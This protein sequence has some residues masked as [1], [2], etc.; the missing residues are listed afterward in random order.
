M[1]TMTPAPIAMTH[2]VTWQD[3]T[4]L[5]NPSFTWAQIAPYVNW[6]V[7]SP[8]DNAN[9][10]AVGIKTVL[11]TDPNRVDAN[12]PEYSND[13]T[14]FA[15]DCSNNRITI[16]G[17]QSLT[18]L[19]DPTS[20]VLEGLWQQHLA[21]YNQGGHAQ[22]NMVFD[23]TPIVASVSALPCGYSQSAW[24]AAENL[25]NIG[26]NYPI[27]FNGLANLANGMGQ[28]SPAMAL[29][30]T[31]SGGEMEGCYSNYSGSP[32]P[33]LTVWHTFEDTEIQVLADGKLF[34]CRGF[35]NTPDTQAQVQ[36]LY[37]YGSFL[38]TYDPALA[39]FS[40]KFK[41]VSNGMWIQPEN[42]LV[43]LDPIMMQPSSIDQLSLGANVYGRQYRNCYYA[44]QWVGACAS[45]VNS[46]SAGASHP[47]PWSGVYQHTLVLSGGDILDGGTASTNGP[48]PQSFIA[49]STATILIQ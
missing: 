37:M 34:V 20:P 30:P 11:Y 28:M 7:V 31:S 32:V 36:R 39:I 24:F 21:N 14:E 13:E 10:Q 18:Y 8:G 9:A 5:Q 48:A 40:P 44:G 38:L 46:D 12:S 33:K 6:S 45:V 49:G 3:D 41:T 23:D 47:M 15:H 17:T 16:T 43:A 29:L 35:D 26:L 25:M 42:Q 22:Y 19:T 2:V 1:P 27:V 4:G